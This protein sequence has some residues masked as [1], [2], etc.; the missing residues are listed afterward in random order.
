MKNLTILNASSKNAQMFAFIVIG[1]SLIGHFE[2]GL[3]DICNI[4]KQCGRTLLPIL[5]IIDKIVE[6]FLIAH[7]C[8]GIGFGYFGRYFIATDIIELD[9][10][11]NVY[12][13]NHPADGRFPVNR[14]KNPTSC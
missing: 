12:C 7:S 14:F 3:N 1:P 5:A 10:V 2:M 6:A 8:D 11:Q 13:V 9:G 4:P